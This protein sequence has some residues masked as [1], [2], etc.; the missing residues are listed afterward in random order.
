[1]IKMTN[2]PSMPSKL[3]VENRRVLPAAEMTQLATHIFQKVGCVEEIAA[4]VAEHLV[5]TNLRG[6]ES[7]GVMR[8]MQYVEQLENGYMQPLGQP[9]LYQNEKGAWIADGQ[10]GFGIPTLHLGVEKG[11]EIAKVQGMSVVAAVNCG[12]TG[13]LGAYVERGAEAGCL[14]ICIGGGG[15]K[16]WP[17]VAPYGGSKGMLPT[18]PYAFGIPGGE[19]GPVVLDFATAKIAGGWIYAAQSAG[20]LLPPDAVIDAAGN[21]T[22][23]PDD[24]Y[25]GGAILPMAGPKGYGLALMAELIGEAMLGEVTTEMNWLFIC[26]DTAL[27]AGGSRYQAIAEGI[28]QEIRSCPP[29]VGFARVEIPGERE[30]DLEAANKDV[31]IAIPEQTWAQILALAERLG[32]S[33]SSLE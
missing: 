15:H 11:I 1:M 17:Q 30:R 19:R 7:H 27:Y 3:E 22:R 2:K 20:V 33:Y 21:P 28:L 8:L 31:G 4:M 6:I 29:A 32:V 10:G 25:N 16:D 23:N 12:H 26:I 14:T 13:R 24:Y 18:N 9:T 5:E